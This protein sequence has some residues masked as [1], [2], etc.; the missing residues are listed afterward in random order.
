METHTKRYFANASMVFALLIAF[1]YVTT[2]IHELGHAVMVWIYG[3]D[4]LQIVV[5]SPISFND[6]AGYVETNMPYTVPV[7]MGGILATTIVAGVLCL[8]ARRTIFSYLM[9]CLSLSTLYNA[10][11]ALSG[12]DDITWL[13]M[14][15]WSS[16]LMVLG[17]V[18]LN[19]YI[20]HQGL[21]DLFD[22]MWEYQTLNKAISISQHMPVISHGWPQAG[23]MSAIEPG[24][25]ILEP[26]S[27]R[28]RTWLHY[29]GRY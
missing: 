19:L 6:V 25:Q 10:A 11:Y 4:V 18:V 28:A 23:K 9:L 15:S 7:V 1:A 20:A 29:H 12:F 26:I 22:D 5:N 17:I 16:A 3:G 27:V 14:Q 24:E 13:V 2:Y 21:K 8:A